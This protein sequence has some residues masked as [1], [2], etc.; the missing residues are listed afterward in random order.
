MNNKS[1]GTTLIEILLSVLLISFVMVF[2]FN[3]L[4]NLKEE[5]NLI[6]VRNEDYLS[7]ASFVRIIQNDL[8]N[9]ENSTISKCSD[10][11]NSK[12]C[13]TLN[14]KKLVVE[15]VNGKGKVTYD[16]EVWNL[17][18]GKYNLQDIIFTYYEP[19]YDIY[20]GKGD[21][22]FLNDAESNY[23]LLKII[24]PVTVDISSNRK[25]DIEISHISA[26]KM[27]KAS[28]ESTFCDDIKTYFK[29]KI[30]ISDSDGKLSSNIKCI[31][32]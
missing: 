23:H 18:N 13:I 25:L 22:R 26:N 20:R 24:I 10:G 21:V 8:I 1:K 31:N 17:T 28:E 12:F 16:N 32:K 14:D 7:R 30:G 9:N 29:N 3:I 19:K 2:L 4:I 5:Y 6:S 11:N 15:N 27:I